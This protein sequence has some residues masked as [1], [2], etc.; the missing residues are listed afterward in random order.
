[1]RIILD[2][3]VLVSGIFF[4]GPPSRILTAWNQGLLTLVV[5][6]EILDEYRRVSQ[7]LNR[8]FPTVNIDAIIDLVVVGAEI[9]QP[10][11]LSEPVCADPDDDKFVACA[12]SAGVGTIVSGDRH[13]LQV[14]GYEGIQVLKPRKFIDT[15]LK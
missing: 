5:S 10:D 15:C 8:K 1:V 9:Y 6:L 3:N 13:L 14:S 12:L 4:A 2:T 11:R 7:E